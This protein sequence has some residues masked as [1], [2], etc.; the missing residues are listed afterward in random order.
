MKENK[1][2]KKKD[3]LLHILS[4]SEQDT[5]SLISKGRKIVEQGQFITDIAQCTK[6]FIKCIPDDSFLPQEKWDDQ[7]FSWNSWRERAA[8]T[9]KALDETKPLVLIAVD[10]T[11]VATTAVISSI[12][13]ASLPKNEQASARSAYDKY[14][15]LLDQSN[16]IQEIEEEISRLSLTSSQPGREYILS[17]VQQADKAFKMPSLEGVSASAV[18]IPLREAINRTFADLLP[19]RQLQEKAKNPKIKI[20]SICKQ[21]CRSAVDTRNIE[22][23]VNQVDDL[24]DKMSGAKQHSMTRDQ[25]RELMNRGLVFLLAFLRMLDE[26]KLRV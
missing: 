10:S 26:N 12:Q 6:D 7:I 2:T 4:D 19:R 18:I 23:L 25:V 14:E 16:L 17:L 22:Q 9:N 11:N 13:V 24:Y 5:Q 21:C 8:D 1:K 20:Q 3:K 15:K